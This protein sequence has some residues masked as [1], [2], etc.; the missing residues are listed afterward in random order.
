MN[1]KRDSL[2]YYEFV[3]PIVST[4]HGVGAR[5]TCILDLGIAADARAAGRCE[6]RCH[7]GVRRHAKRRREAAAG[8]TA[9]GRQPRHADD[10]RGCR[11][12]HGWVHAGRRR[13]A[14]RRRRRCDARRGRCEDRRDGEQRRDQESQWKGGDRAPGTLEQPGRA[15]HACRVH[16][17]SPQSGFRRPRRSDGPPAHGCA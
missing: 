9:V 3:L 1:W 10:R 13:E 6:A 5:T 4:G 8:R 2:G 12:R 17:S 14:T 15:P 7:G 11:A 16:F